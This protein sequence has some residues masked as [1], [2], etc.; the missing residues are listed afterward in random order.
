MLTYSCKVRL[1][2]NLQ[3]EVRKSGV[4]APAIVMLRAIHGGEGSVV[5]IVNDGEIKISDGEVRDD[6]VREY[7][8]ARVQQILGVGGVPLPQEVPGVA[9][10]RQ[11]QLER[12]TA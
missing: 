3:N 6:L 8:A 2:D 1:G 4:T 11:S 5:D 9:K 10:K 12:M 7:G